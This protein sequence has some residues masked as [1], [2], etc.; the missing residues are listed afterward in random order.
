MERELG[1]KRQNGEIEKERCR[2]RS[3]AGERERERKSRRRERTREWREMR[4]VSRKI[5]SDS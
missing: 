4:A 1:G 2:E 3:V 5:G